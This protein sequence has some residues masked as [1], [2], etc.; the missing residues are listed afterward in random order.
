MFVPAKIRCKFDDESI[1][2]V[3]TI[4]IRKEGVS[5]LVAKQSIRYA[6]TKRLPHSLFLSRSTTECKEM[7]IGYDPRY[8]QREKD[9]ERIP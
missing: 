9:T 8:Q 4:A 6:L 2:S 7:T 3:L 5:R 1:N